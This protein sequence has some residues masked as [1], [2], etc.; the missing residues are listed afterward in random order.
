MGVQHAQTGMVAEAAKKPARKERRGLT[1]S[2]RGG[3]AVD[4]PTSEATACAVYGRPRSSPV[5]GFAAFGNIRSTMRSQRM[6]GGM[7]VCYTAARRVQ[8]HEPPGLPG[9]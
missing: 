3:S 1:C 4:P 9:A 8:M 5:A 6:F 2:A 7:H